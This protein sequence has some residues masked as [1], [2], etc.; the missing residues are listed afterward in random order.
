M[1]KGDLGEGEL[2]LRKATDG[3]VMWASPVKGIKTKNKKLT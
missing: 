2:A 3:K 1:K